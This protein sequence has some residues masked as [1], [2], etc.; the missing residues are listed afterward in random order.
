[1]RIIV[2]ALFLG[3]SLGACT[4]G[5]FSLG[6][7]TAKNEPAAAGDPQNSESETTSEERKVMAKSTLV[8]KRYRSLESGVA[9]ALN[10][11]KEQL[12]VEA[13]QHSCIDKVHL[14]VLGGNE[15]FDNGQY[16]RAD[17][18]SVLTALAVDRVIISACNT[19]IA[20]DK[21]GTAEVFK[22]FALSS[23]SVTAEQARAQGTELY[24]RFLARD[25]S[26]EE[27][28]VIANFV[29]SAGNGEQA[30]LA[31]CY[32]IGTHSENIFL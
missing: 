5:K 11:P 23:A 7:R 9:A 32:A 10:V 25:P 12:C 13:G 28:D 21:A 22:H 29:S 26:K 27:L 20:M 16:E 3:L 31:L 1:M 24:Q 30:A 4:K 14:T 15:P 19:R 2:T 18:P 6:N 8:W 17:A